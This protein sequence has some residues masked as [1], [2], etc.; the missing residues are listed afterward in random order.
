MRGQRL[1]EIKIED[2]NLAVERLKRVIKPTPIITM[3]MLNQTFGKKIYF[4]TECLL[5]TGSFKL[6][7]AYNK[8]SSIS[9]N[10][11][12]KGVIT[13]SSG[14]HAISVSLASKWLKCKPTVLVPS[15]VPHIKIRTCKQLGAEV[16]AIGD[17]YDEAYDKAKQISE[18]EGKC[19]IH[20]VADTDVIAGQATIGLEILQQMSYVKQVI[21]PLGGGGLVSGIAIAIKQ[22]DPSVKIIAV[23]PEGSSAYYQ[24]ILNNKITRLNDVNTIADGLALK[25][26]EPFL[27]EQ[28]KQWVDDVVVVKESTI[29]KAIKILLYKGK[30]L[31]EGAGA[32]AFAALMDECID[33]EEE[34][35]CIASGSNIDE[36]RLIDIL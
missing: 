1:D 17:S 4:K 34:T 26:P 21:V 28:I 22:I 27:Y 31:V 30:I 6:R 19:Y 13:A 10:E 2:I 5:P 8:I 20:P 24:S 3:E 29:R 9:Y 15:N 12:K 35:V 32:V 7:G 16:I 33:W 25:K 11:R 36:S 14:N 23:Q 18:I